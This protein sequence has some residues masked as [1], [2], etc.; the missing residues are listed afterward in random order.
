MQEIQVDK[1]TTGKGFSPIESE[2]KYF[3]MYCEQRLKKMTAVL[4][5]SSHSKKQNT[6]QQFTLVYCNNIY[7]KNIFHTFC[8]QCCLR[9]LLLGKA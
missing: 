4:I 8:T 6:K 9:S 3:Q 5:R 7:S 2:S 1:T